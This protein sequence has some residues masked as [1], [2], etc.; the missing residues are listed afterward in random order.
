[1]PSAEGNEIVP[2]CQTVKRSVL[3]YSPDDSRRFGK[4]QDNVLER[5]RKNELRTPNSTV[6]CM[7]TRTHAVP[8]KERTPNQMLIPCTIN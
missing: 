7:D 5:G 2:R 1:M 3:I 4:Q 8:L 6:S